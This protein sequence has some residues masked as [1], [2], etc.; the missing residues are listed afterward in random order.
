MDSHSYCMAV[1]NM[2]A[3]HDFWIH[4]CQFRAHLLPISHIWVCSTTAPSPTNAHQHAHARPPQHGS[5][6]G[7][8]PAFRRGENPSACI[9]SYLWNVSIRWSTWKKNPLH[10]LHHATSRHAFPELSS[11]CWQ[12]NTCGQNFIMRLLAQ[13]PDGTLMCCASDTMLKFVDARFL[14]L[15]ETTTPAYVLSCC[16]HPH[17]VITHK[18]V[19]HFAYFHVDYTP[20]RHKP[21]NSDD[22]HA[23]VHVF[24]A[25]HALPQSL[26][27]H[28]SLIFSFL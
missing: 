12:T 8:K 28:E 4:R 19:W 1:P 17:K 15:Y 18:V 10:T 13:S 24:H 9:S 25:P 23:F 14:K 20:C 11:V 27:A 3:P 2:L 21:L 7:T 26:Q 22:E 6:P 5:R 16:F